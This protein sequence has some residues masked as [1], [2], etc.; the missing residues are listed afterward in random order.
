[1]LQ[2]MATESANVDRVTKSLQNPEVVVRSTL[3]FEHTVL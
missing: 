1:M 2:E 3:G